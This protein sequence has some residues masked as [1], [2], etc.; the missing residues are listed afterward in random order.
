MCVMNAEYDACNSEGGLIRVLQSSRR[1]RCSQLLPGRHQPQ[2]GRPSPS[3]VPRSPW[4]LHR[5]SDASLAATRKQGKKWSARSSVI[6][7]T[8]SLLCSPLQTLCTVPLKLM[9]FILNEEDVTKRSQACRIFR[10][11]MPRVHVCTHAVS[12]H[13]YMHGSSTALSVFR[14]VRCEAEARAG[15]GVIRVWYSHGI[16]VTTTLQSRAVAAQEFCSTS[17][18]GNCWRLHLA[19]ICIF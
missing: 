7:N 12:Q 14:S 19:W 11:H 4:G 1:T 15:H 16:W 17:T 8:R 6:G 10:T 2:K 3:H 13:V 9:C 18:D 5:R